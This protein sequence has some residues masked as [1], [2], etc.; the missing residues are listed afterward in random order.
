MRR[1]LLV[2]D[3]HDVRHLVRLVLRQ[4][5]TIDEVSSGQEALKRCQEERYAAIILDHRMSRMTGLEVAQQLRQRGD[6]T[7]IVLFSAFLDPD[8]SDRAEALQV[9]VVPKDDL[10]QLVASLPADGGPS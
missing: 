6:D 1:L 8:M 2:D 5:W 7:A 4:E 9:T 10:E 3:D